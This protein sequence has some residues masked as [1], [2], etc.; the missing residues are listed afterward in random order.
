MDVTKEI[1]DRFFKNEAEPQ[2]A[3]AV[4]RYFEKH[5]EEA[6]N[7][8]REMEQFTTGHRLHPAVSESMFATIEGRMER[9]QG[10][11]ILFYR[12]AAAASI[13]LAIAASGLFLI[14]HKE[15]RQLAEKTAP[16]RPRLV[17]LVNTSDTIM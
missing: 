2:E 7:Y 16:A 17:Q 10:R 4:K 6:I 11:R 13:I 1:I 12:M 5:P 9:R 3:E 14:N 8:A 15:S